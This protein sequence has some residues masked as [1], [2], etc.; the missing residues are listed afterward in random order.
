MSDPLVN[1]RRTVYLQGWSRAGKKSPVFPT[2][3][4]RR[5]W[6]PA[7]LL[8]LAFFPA[9]LSAQMEKIGELWRWVQFTTEVG[10]PS[11]RVF[12]IVETRS[13]TIWAITQSGLAWYDG[14]C[15]HAAGDAS[16]LPRIRVRK[17]AECSDNQL[18]VL[19]DGHLFRGGLS[20][21]REIF[22][23]DRGRR[24]SVTDVATL[25]GVR[26]LAISDS[27][28][29]E[30]VNDSLRTYAVP[31]EIS[32]QKVLSLVRGG[33]RRRSFDRAQPI[34]ARENL[35]QLYL[36][37]KLRKARRG[38]GDGRRSRGQHPDRRHDGER[39]DDALP[40][41]IAATG[42]T[43]YFHFI[44]PIRSAVRQSLSAFSSDAVFERKK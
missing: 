42:S 10:L 39:H 35:G 8:I 20:G 37:E 17:I 31:P 6:A 33:G 25:P 44:A 3:G 19:V 34:G 40:A 14:Y 18:L 2:R 5:R 24:K 22:F 21:F 13:G 16:G 4:D 1:T 43:F 12:D 26:I 7:F 27:V 11:N 36:V 32:G 41:G 15:W 38:L 23:T 30:V 28:L 29:C 9:V